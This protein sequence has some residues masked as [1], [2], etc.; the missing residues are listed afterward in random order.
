MHTDA[1]NRLQLESDLRKALVDEQFELMYQ[2][3]MDLADRRTTGL[4]ALIRWRHPTRGLVSPIEFLP[5]AES[6]GLILPIGRWTIRE[7]CRRLRTWRD[8]SPEAA[9]LT[10]SVNLSNRQFWDPELR[11]Y[12]QAA[13]REYGLPPT[14]L[15]FEMT[16]GVIMH[17][18]ES[19][20]NLMRQFQADGIKLHVDDFGTGYSSLEALHQFPIDAL[21]IDK[22]FIDRMNVD[23]RSG[24]LVRFM[25]E[26]GRNLGLDVIVEGVE[27]EDQAERLGKM[28]HPLVQGYLFARPLPADAVPQ[29]FAGR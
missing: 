24:E 2:P 7:V 18:R 1:M 19:A 15:I 22:S 4:E 9:G 21:K 5:V 27:T 23:E 17:N 25:I 11:S 26:M 29:L 6:T 28:G 10:V 16:E 8:A 3:I 13:L 20:I 12:V 14:A